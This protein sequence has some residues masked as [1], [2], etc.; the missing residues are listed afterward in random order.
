MI[1]LTIYSNHDKN[2]IMLNNLFSFLLNILVK[3]CDN[4]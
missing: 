3:I 2:Y 1:K 4:K